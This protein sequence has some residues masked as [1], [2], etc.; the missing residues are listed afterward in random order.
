M[1]PRN[2]RKTVSFGR[3]FEDIDEKYGI[4][5]YEILRVRRS[6][7]EQCARMLKYY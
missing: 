4:Y 1:S 2:G 6:P 5:S 7:Y 3:L